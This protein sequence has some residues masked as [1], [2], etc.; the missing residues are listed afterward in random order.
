MLEYRLEDYCSP[1]DN[2]TIHGDVSFDFSPAFNAIMTQ[3]AASH[4][5]AAY[6]PKP[7]R[8]I[9][10]GRP[11]YH[12]YST[13]V[14]NHPVELVGIG[15]P[16]RSGSVRL[17]FHGCDGIHI[18]RFPAGNSSINLGSA[19]I[20]GLSIEYV[21]SNTENQEYNGITVHRSSMMSRLSIRNFPAHGIHIQGTQQD[22]SIDNANV[23]FSQLRDSTVFYNGKS[24]VWIQG[25]DA[26][27]CQIENVNSFSNGKREIDG[28]C[29]GFFDAS[30]LGNTYTACHTRNNFI[31][32]YCASN[33]APGAPARC[34]FVNCY[35]EHSPQ[36]VPAAQQEGP[37]L[38]NAN[39]LVI[40]SNGDGNLADAIGGAS[41]MNTT[42][43]R[44]Q[45][46]DV[47][48]VL[49][50][51]GISTITGDGTVK[52]VGDTSP[53][54]INKYRDTSYGTSDAESDV[55]YFVKDPNPFSRTWGFKTVT[56]TSVAALGIT[57][58]KHLRPGKAIAPRGIL[59]GTS[60]NRT[61][62]E[63]G[64]NDGAR[65]IGVHDPRSEGTLVATFPTPLLGDTVLSSVPNKQTHNFR[66]WV[67]ARDNGVDKWFR[68]GEGF[69][70]TPIP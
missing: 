54:V 52:T 53:R 9:F 15:V 41:I 39:C 6:P 62:A 37:A 63:H 1:S 13:L 14:V 35:T 70:G 12:F 16:Y 51:N 40:T 43:G 44:L 7:A 64:V 45:F 26:Q 30:M 65:L 3:L 34:M 24:G 47:I 59:I 60:A 4:T 10:D 49:G 32:G 67:F 58:R 61:V 55:L 46:K 18:R 11:A 36:P 22:V 25:K 42:L 28:D 29:Y 33:Y 38:L 19:F 69:L 31:S 48:E 21:G 57:D 50:K 17:L 56:T 8:I 27:V 5:N 68:Y 2:Q 20:E 66:G 23:S